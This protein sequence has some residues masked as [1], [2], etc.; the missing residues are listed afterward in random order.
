[1][2][3]DYF[4]R[5]KVYGFDISDFS[6]VKHP[7][8][9]FVRGD[10]GSAEDMNRLA[11]TASVFDII[12]DDGSHASY[13]QQLA[14]KHLFPR[15]RSGGTYIIEDLQ[16]QSPSFEGKSPLLPK[17][18]DFMINYFEHN[19]YVKNELL[20]EDFMCFVKENLTSYAWFPAFD[21]KASPAKL[22]VFRK[23]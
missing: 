23:I 11:H 18:R 2:W 13:H 15:L 6:H 1:M 19:K 12:L 10:G 20:T 3:L 9:I 8:F 21:G 7:R 16:W 14:F 4:P 17:T 5:G 22:F